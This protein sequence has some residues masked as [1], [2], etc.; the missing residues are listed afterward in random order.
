MIVCQSAPPASAPEPR[1]TARS[2]F[3]FGTEDF[4]AFW[5]ASYSVGLPARSPPPTRAATSMFL[6]SFANSLPRRES[7]TAFLC[8]VVAHFEWPDIAA[9]LR[10]LGGSHQIHEVPVHAVVP[11]QFGVE[12]GRQQRA[13]A[14]GDNPTERLGRGGVPH[15]GEH[16]HVR[17]G[18]LD[19]GRPDEHRAERPLRFGEIVGQVGLE[20]VH[21]TAEGV[22]ADHH[23]QATDGLLALAA[24]G[25]TLM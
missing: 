9:L 21:L 8:L 24:G 2:M 4:F 14:H 15:P 5:T 11:G 19:P 1:L 18:G 12:G 25:R 13:L 16:G 20:G 23:V 22:A 10:S 3:S 7:I 17:P 6:I